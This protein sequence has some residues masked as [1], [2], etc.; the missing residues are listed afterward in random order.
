VVRVTP[1]LLPPLSRCDA[2]QVFP[3]SSR[4]GTGYSKP[5]LVHAFERVGFA[6]H[7]PF[8]ELTRPVL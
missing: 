1:L 3:R 4:A 2:R 7:L 8:M 5:D 6:S